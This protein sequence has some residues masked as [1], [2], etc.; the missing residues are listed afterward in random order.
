[1]GA[2]GNM[3]YG[4]VSHGEVGWAHIA[5]DLETVSECFGYTEVDFENMG[6]AVVATLGTTLHHV[7][8]CHSQRVQ[9]WGCSEFPG[10]LKIGISGG[11]V[12]RT[13][14]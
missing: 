13:T 8:F 14:K 7:P 2:I 5:V 10:G 4:G 3:L 1:M 6:V 12:S 9:R 11:V